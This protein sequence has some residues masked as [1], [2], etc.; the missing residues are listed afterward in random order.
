VDYPSS[1]RI[2]QGDLL[3]T[4]QNTNPMDRLLTHR[5]PH[6]LSVT[7]SGAAKIECLDQRH[8]AISIEFIC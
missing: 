1:F 5:T 3:E 8:Q 7:N 2:R 4:L 6:L